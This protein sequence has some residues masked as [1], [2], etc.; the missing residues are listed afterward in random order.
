MSYLGNS[1][2]KF[3]QSVQG[4]GQTIAGVDA[5]SRYK[6]TAFDIATKTDKFMQSLLT[7]PDHGTPGAVD[8][9][10][11]GYIGQWEQF[12]AEVSEQ[13]EA[14]ANPFAR[15]KLRDYWSQAQLEGRAAVEKSQ[16]EAWR[17]DTVAGAGRRI[18]NMIKTGG[19]R[20]QEAF[21]YAQQELDDLRDQNL[22]TESQ[23]QESMASYSQS[24][25]RAGLLEQAKGA[26]Q[27]KGLEAALLLIANDAETYLAGGQSYTAGDEVKAL[28]ESD[29]KAY[30]GVIQDEIFTGM[31][32]QFAQYYL[33]KEQRSPGVVPL[34]HLAIEQSK[35]DADKKLYWHAQLSGY[36]SATA[37]SADTKTQAYS[38]EN[39]IAL[40]C[41]AYKRGGTLG[42]QPF[43]TLY[44]QATGEDEQYPIYSIEGIRKML[45]DNFGAIQGVSGMASKCLG[46]IEDA[47]RGDYGP[48]KS[49]YDAVA[50]IKDLGL[51]AQYRAYFDNLRAQ[52]GTNITPQQL[53]PL[54][55]EMNAASYQRTMGTRFLSPG[56]LS[57]AED[58]IMADLWGGAFSFDVTGG[59]GSAL[60]P[61]DPRTRASL[62]SFALGFEKEIRSGGGLSAEDL[63]RLEFRWAVSSRGIPGAADMTAVVRRP[64][65]S[66]VFFKAVPVIGKNGKREAGYIRQTTSK[67]GDVATELFDPWTGS[68]VAVDPIAAEKPEGWD[69]AAIPK[70]PKAP[71]GK[72]PDAPPTASA[73]GAFN[74]TTWVYYND[75]GTQIQNKKTGQILELVNGVWVDDLTRKPVDATK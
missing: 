58:V 68:M 39:A 48:W 73:T 57:N 22:I 53:A 35:A 24:I 40:A 74:S 45:T 30:H 43:V 29:L 42:G 71:K 2:E 51:Q 63:Q 17:D 31:E 70:A 14:E 5:E 32:Q 59:P 56:V 21:D 28:V 4:I 69:L 18:I 34:T 62:E 7:N 55:S 50:K 54:I 12:N 49:V 19:A 37:G 33:P 75:A 60:R 46:Y 66:R 15:K 64:D 16:F 36:L 3:G 65:G 72:T 27:E 38:V 1:L 61:M 9:E 13:I 52:Q 11:S 41:D 23:Y 44:N 26:Y 47:E 67:D 8:T 6:D 20:G 10:G 25:I